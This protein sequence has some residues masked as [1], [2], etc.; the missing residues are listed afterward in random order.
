MGYA[1]HTRRGKL[2]VVVDFAEYFNA[3]AQSKNGRSPIWDHY[4]VAMIQKVA[5]V[6]ALRRQFPLG[7]I[8][9]AEEMGLM[10]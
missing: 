3:N 8:V 4:P 9:A 6:S 1:E 10:K 5:E 2:P 7:G